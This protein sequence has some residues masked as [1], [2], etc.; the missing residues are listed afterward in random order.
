[1]RSESTFNEPG[2][3]D[4]PVGL[5]ARQRVPTGFKGARRDK[6][7][8]W[9]F[10]ERRLLTLMALATLLAADGVFAQTTLIR[11]N[12]VGYLPSRPKKASVA[13]SCTN[14]LILRTNDSSIAYSNVV[15]GPVLNSDTSENLYTADFS[16]LTEAGTFRLSV[17]GVGVSAPFRIAGDVYE[18]AYYTA[19]R[20]MY[21][22]RCGTAVSGT[23]NG[24]TFSHAICHTNDAWQDYIGGGHVKKNGL[25][26]WHD[27]GD[28]NKYVANAGVT[29]GSM[30]RAWETSGAGLQGIP[31]NLPESGGALPD[32]LAELKWELDWLLTMQ[33]ADGSVYHKVSTL[34]FGGFIAPEAETTARYFVP[35]GSTAT[36]DF[37]AM[38]AQA[39]R[40]IRPYDP[41]YADTCLAAASN[42]Y[43][44]LVAN[45]AYH[46]ADQSGFST[47]GYESSDGDDRLWAA[48]ELWETT[49]NPSVL[50]D[51]ETRVNASKLVNSDFDWSNVKNLGMFTY[52]LSQRPGR[53]LSLVNQIRQ[54]LTNTANGIVNTRNG[55][56]YNRPLGTSYYWGCNG[57]VARQALTLLAAHRVAPRPE[58]LDTAL[59]AL[60]HL[61]GRNY[62]GR[63]FVTGIGYL[64]P[65]QPHDRRSLGGI[66]PAWPGYLVGG[67]WP[68]AKDWVDD[69]T[70]YEVNEIA[71]NWNGALIY[72]LAAF[73]DPGLE[74]VTDG[75]YRLSPALNGAAALT[76][77]SVPP[78]NNTP[79]QEFTWNDGS[80]QHW[81][82]QSV[83][84]NYFR[85]SPQ[86]DTGSALE[87]RYGALTNGTPIVINPWTGGQ[88]QQWS[89]ANNGDGS[90]RLTPRLYAGAAL[91]VAN[92][93]T[94]NGTPLLANTWN[95]SL[96]QRWYVMGIVVTNANTAPVLSPLSNQVVN[97]GQTVTF[98]ASATDTNLPA[99]T[100][101]YSLLSAPTNAALDGSSGQFTWRPLPA[102]ADTTN[103]VT[104]RVMDNGLPSMSATQNCLVAV[105]PLVSPSLGAPSWNAGRLTFSIAGASGPDYAVQTSTNLTDWDT[106]FITNSPPLPFTWVDTNETVFPNRFY[107]V[108]IGPPLP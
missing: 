87:L 104:V 57:S 5:D 66:A 32:Y 52:V 24:Q 54:N 92:A 40:F 43:A 78:T 38:L 96:A 9:S 94:N 60:S 19:T 33:A 49:G 1:M 29:V 17:P 36:A 44:F 91:T 93:N 20:G 77:P 70:D 26:G 84:A 14:F 81:V 98:T 47:G 67:G 74:T 99:Q 75:W 79:A 48:A 13:T 95:G 28:Y 106:P 25:K 30:L 22:W 46:A 88:A 59:D 69:W 2:R 73:A 37:V 53:N 103:L 41:V 4:L 83:E 62:Y 89:I 105:N 86:A 7:P 58:Y 18:Q 72:A 64:P 10:H 65:T 82:V 90:F 107:R 8:G 11:F 31:L 68:G 108:K 39:S 21:L 85:I 42:S 3:A 76:L 71:I 101:T 34:N 55:H 102:Q 61:L 35:W 50:A 15:T 80:A 23:N 45:P 100:L 51:L 6:S 56:G 63:S 97:P 12:T 27:A 16:A